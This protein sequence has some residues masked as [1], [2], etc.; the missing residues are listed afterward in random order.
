[1]RPFPILHS[2]QT[3]AERSDPQNIFRI[4][5]QRRNIVARKSVG[6]L[7]RSKFSVAQTIQSAALCS[8]PQIAF[9]IFRNG[10]HQIRGQSIARRENFPFFFIPSRQAALR[11]DPDMSRAIL[12]DGRDFWINHACAAWVEKRHSAIE[13]I[14][15]QTRVALRPRPFAGDPL[16]WREC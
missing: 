9:G 3:T 4:D 11:S 1:M 14:Q 7:K 6:L 10:A 5:I 8:N 15:R 16:E 13:T 12:K 2:D